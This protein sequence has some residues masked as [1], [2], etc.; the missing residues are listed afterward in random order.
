MSSSVLSRRSLFRAAGVAAVGRCLAARKKAAAFALIGDRYHNSDYIRVALG[1]TIVRDAGVSVDFCDEVKMLDAETLDGYRLLIILR[2]GMTWPDGYPDESSNA[3]YL[4]AGSPRVASV[5]PV[6][7]TEAKP[8]YWI[9]PE[10][11][12]AVKEFVERGGAALFFHNVTYISPH[13]Q[14]FRDV[15]GAVTEDH[16]PIRKF[17]VRVVN[18][19]HP[20]TRGVQDFVVTD[21]QHF[22]RY[23]KDPKYLLLESVNEDGLTWKNLGAKSPA[24]WAYGYGKGRVCYLAPGHLLAALWNPEYVKLQK[25]AVRWLLGEA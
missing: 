5:P 16:P 1:R 8:H 9:T 20:I 22:M 19:G 17:K 12:R 15:L 7:K 13:N 24:G 3:A 21:E 10:Q 11:G 2:D 18:P 25:N 4:E 6:P 23:E 14:D